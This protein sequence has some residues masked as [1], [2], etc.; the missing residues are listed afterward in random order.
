MHNDDNDNDDSNN[1]KSIRQARQRKRTRQRLTDC[2][3]L[4]CVSLFIIHKM[5]LCVLYLFVEILFD[6]SYRNK[7]L[8]EPQF[9]FYYYNLFALK[10]LFFLIF[11]F[12]FTRLPNTQKKMFWLH[13][14]LSIYISKL[15][16][17]EVNECIDRIGPCLCIG[18]NMPV[19]CMR[20]V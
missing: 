3:Q 7:F 13:Q 4:K 20:V 9:F 10:C 6:F 8:V 16:W 12:L 2:V 1:N 15:N 14:L 17:N 19:L 11:S 5:F 18:S